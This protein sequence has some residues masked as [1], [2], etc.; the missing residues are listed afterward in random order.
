MKPYLILAFCGTLLTCI[1]GSGVLADH[2]SSAQPEQQVENFFRPHEHTNNW[3]VLVCTS[4]FWFNYRHMANTLSMYRTVKRLG[5]PDSNIILM[6]ADDAACNSRNKV[7]GTVYD[8]PSKHIDLYGQN[9]GVD[10]RGYDVTVENFIRL[11]TGRVHPQTPRSKR[12]LTDDKSNVF[13]YMT[14]HGGDGFLKFQDAE[15]ISSHD[16]A[17]AFAQM[18]EKQRYR[19]ILFMVDTCQANTMYTQ[20]YSPNIV[21]VGSS[22]KGENSYSYF[23]D[24]DLGVSV[25]DR[26]T[27]FNLEF[28]ENVDSHSQTTFRQLFDSY[29]PSLINSHPAVRTDLYPK[30]LDQVPLTDFLGGVQNVELTRTLPQSIAEWVPSIGSA[31]PPVTAESSTSPP[32]SS[33][34]LSE[35]ATLQAVR[36]SPSWYQTMVQYGVLALVGWS[37]WVSVV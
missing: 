22:A 28:L 4:R 18:W 2:G 36:S 23:H 25:I 15:E 17:D 27:Y 9:V 3:A 13:I 16:L 32:S 7:P 29:D 14:G 10:Y 33:P 5:I 34:P 30:P 6:L 31:A 37:V 26:F 24:H 12:L 1:G 21:S 11:L 8:H 35:P 19:E 20:F